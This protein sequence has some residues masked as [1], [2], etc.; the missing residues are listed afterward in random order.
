MQ[1]S[2][3]GRDDFFQIAGFLLPESG[4]IVCGGLPGVALE[5][6][7]KVV[8]VQVPHLGA[9]LADGEIGLL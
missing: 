2:L 1:R 9:D 7:H 8:V 4:P 3:P 5:D 6:L